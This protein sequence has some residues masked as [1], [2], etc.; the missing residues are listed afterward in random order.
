MSV[1]FGHTRDAKA[2]RAHKA[3]R[4]RLAAIGAG[5]TPELL[6]AA[7]HPD[8]GRDATDLRRRLRRAAGV[9]REP[10]T[11]TWT[12]A[13]VELER[14]PGRFLPEPDR[15]GPGPCGCWPARDTGALY[16][17]PPTPTG[18]FGWPCPHPEGWTPPVARPPLPAAPAPARWWD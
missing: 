9:D 18:P 13:L 16:E 1:D 3:G 8:A 4:L 6:R 17:F 10:S 14:R 2:N 5:V 12:L 11:E 7:L 15:A